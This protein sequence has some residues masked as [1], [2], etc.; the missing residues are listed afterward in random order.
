[1][2]ASGATASVSSYQ[3]RKAYSPDA[4]QVVAQGALADAHDLGRIF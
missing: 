2:T 4:G 1:M 3:S